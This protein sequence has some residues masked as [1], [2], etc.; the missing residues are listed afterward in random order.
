MCVRICF[1]FQ[2]VRE[3]LEDS[4]LREA[5]ALAKVSSLSRQ[6]ANAQSEAAGAVERANRLESQNRGLLQRMQ[7]PLAAKGSATSVVSVDQALSPISAELQKR[8]DALVICRAQVGSEVA[9]ANARVAEEVAARRA[10]EERIKALTVLADSSQLQVGLFVSAV[11]P[12]NGVVPP[13]VS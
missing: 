9:A 6:L 5:D 12:A 3:T 1:P 10:A 11:L 13:A 7:V 4:Q 2:A 8:V